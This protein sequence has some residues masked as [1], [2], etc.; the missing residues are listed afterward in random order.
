MKRLRP[1]YWGDQENQKGWRRSTA[2][3]QRQDRQGDIS[4]GGA[5]DQSA[6]ATTGKEP[7]PQN[8]YLRRDTVHQG[9]TE[10]AYRRSH[11]S[12]RRAIK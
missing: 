2:L 11:V 3:D 5:R 8:Y 4:S 6:P 1:L 7:A 9:V 10:E 12:P